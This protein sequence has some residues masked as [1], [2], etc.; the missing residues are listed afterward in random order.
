M[1][2]SQGETFSV[3]KKS[4]RYDMFSCA[5]DTSKS[6]LQFGTQAQTLCRACHVESTQLI[7]AKELGGF[8]VFD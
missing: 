3:E 5:E 2:H 6:L 7:K 4:L 8:C 1:T